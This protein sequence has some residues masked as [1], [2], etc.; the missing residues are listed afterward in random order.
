MKKKIIHYLAITNIFLLIY[1][2]FQNKVLAESFVTNSKSSIT[3]FPFIFM[4]IFCSIHMSVFV[5]LPLSKIISKNKPTTT[6]CVL[7]IIRLI[8]LVI[9]DIIN[10]MITAIVDFMAIFIGAFILIPVIIGLRK[11]TSK[12]TSN[13]YTDVPDYEFDNI[14]I[15]NPD[16]FKKELVNKFIKYE[17]AYCN[18]D[19]TY[20]KKNTSDTLYKM[21]EYSLNLSREKG[22]KSKTT[23]IKEIDCKICS[24]TNDKDNITVCMYL[25][26][27]LLDYSVDLV[28]N[29]IEGSSTKR[30][31]TEYI[32][33]F[34]KTNPKNSNIIN[35][36]NCGSPTTETTGKYC[37]YCGS[38][39]NKTNNDWILKKCTKLK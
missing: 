38:S 39:L 23:D 13:G 34:E 4:E 1:I 30:K 8:L 12:K 6:F 33:I 21:L 28:G 27:S 25:K 14:G 10:P 24:I 7:F 20:L 5:L 11:E 26:A 29:V 22:I 15:K 36:L 17:E 35:C 18:E 2:T 16:I 31:T 37:K 3:L 32:L 19:Y 9:G